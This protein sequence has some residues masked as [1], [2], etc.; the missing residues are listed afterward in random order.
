MSRRL[1]RAPLRYDER[2]ADRTPVHTVD[3]PATP[4]RD[5]N[6]VASAWIE[7]PP[8]LIASRCRPAGTAGGGLQAAHRTVA[9]VACRTRR[10]RRRPLLGGADETDLSQQHTFRLF[11]DGNGDGVAVSGVRHTRFRAW[12]EDLIGRTSNDRR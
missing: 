11:P 5:R 3:L 1:Q 6:I 2:P 10:R 12:K 9:A 4:T 7:A 8:A